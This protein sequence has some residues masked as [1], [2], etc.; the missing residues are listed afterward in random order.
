MATPKSKKKPETA[1]AA[2]AIAAVVAEVTDAELDQLVGQIRDLKRDATFMFVMAVGHLIVE[3]FYAGDLKAWRAIGAKDASFRKLAA[4]LKAE[5]GLRL[6][7]SSLSRA[8]G[9]YELVSTVQAVATSQH[10]RVG[11]Y[12]AVL[13]LPQ[14]SAERLLTKADAER[15]PVPRIRQE[16]A[17]HRKSDGRGRKP[18]LP[19]VKGIHRFQ[20]L[21]DR[22][23]EL[24]AGVERIEEVKPEDAD[25]LF[26][27][28]MH[29]GNELERLKNAVRGRT[30]AYQVGKANQD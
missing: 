1:I 23:D 18:S 5:D 21:L 15:W 8:V 24:L 6:D 20:T 30:S 16:A 7:H 9:V 26:S 22:K 25:K 3:R 19:F 28:L 11:H 29:L 2:P 4:R 12:V 17:K 13:G 14:K 10:L 27:T